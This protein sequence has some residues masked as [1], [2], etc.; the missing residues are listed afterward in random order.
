M[1]RKFIFLGAVALCIGACAPQ[2]PNVKRSDELS[3]TVTTTSWDRSKSG[4]LSGSET[5]LVEA[6]VL[7]EK[8]DFPNR[9]ITVRN[10]H[11]VLETYNVSPAV[12]RLADIKPGDKIVLSY[13]RS[14]AF[15]VRQPTAAEIANPRAFAADI[16]RNPA[17][18]PPG[19][20]ADMVSRTIVTVEEIDLD[21]NTVTVKTPEGKNVTVFARFPENL[22]RV[23]VGDKVAVTYGEALAVD[24]KPLT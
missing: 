9:R 13:S 17:Q 14:L 15:E 5:K 23:K 7:V 12:K 18:L 4:P 11:D 2:N 8:V 22:T 10:A 19:M 3:P 21:A 1:S 16:S 20:T 6:S 24:V